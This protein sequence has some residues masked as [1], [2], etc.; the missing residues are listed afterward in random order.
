[1]ETIFHD[2]VDY[3]D[4]KT[5]LVDDLMKEV[6]ILSHIENVSLKTKNEEME[7]QL[8]TVENMFQTVVTEQSR[9]VTSMG[10]CWIGVLVKF[11]YL[12]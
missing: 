10:N 11:W 2:L 5:D 7:N 1:M 9:R 8:K 4:N 12:H 6:K 3:F